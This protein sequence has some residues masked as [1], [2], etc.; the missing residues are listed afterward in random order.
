MV[1]QHGGTLTVEQS[2]E[3]G[4]A[5]FRAVFP[6]EVDAESIRGGGRKLG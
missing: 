5:L 4:G 6:N 2:R 1:K 3:L